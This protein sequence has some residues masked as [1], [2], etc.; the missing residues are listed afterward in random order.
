MKK[1]FFIATLLVAG[2]TSAKNADASILK[3]DNVDVQKTKT[4]ESKEITVNNKPQF[5]VTFSCGITL[6]YD[7][8]TGIPTKTILAL[9]F[10]YDS[11]LCGN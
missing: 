4:V 5:P 6:N 7:V 11:I 2:M 1:L 10:F 3:A 9:I 8:E